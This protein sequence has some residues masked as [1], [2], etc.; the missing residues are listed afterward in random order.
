MC[1][2]MCVFVCLSVWSSPKVATKQNYQS[3]SK[4]LCVKC[5][6]WRIYRVNQCNM[7]SDSHNIL[8]I[9]QQIIYINEQTLPRPPPLRSLPLLVAWGWV[10]FCLFTSGSHLCNCVYLTFS[11]KGCFVL[12]YGVP[13]VV[14]VPQFENPALDQCCVRKATQL[15]FIQRLDQFENSSWFS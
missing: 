13:Q 8:Q 14:R 2:C 15:P 5:K 6:Q 4:L 9:H 1:L 3:P 7:P 12:F 10:N 11:K